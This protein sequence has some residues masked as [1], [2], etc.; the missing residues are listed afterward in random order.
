MALNGRSLGA[1]TVLRQGTGRL[2]RER[3]YVSSDSLTPLTSLGSSQ[4]KI[5]SELCT[6]QTIAWNVDV[7][8]IVIHGNP[9]DLCTNVGDLLGLKSVKFSMSSYVQVR[10]S[11]WQEITWSLSLNMTARWAMLKWWK[12]ICYSFNLPTDCE[13]VVSYEDYLFILRKLQGFVFVSETGLYNSFDT[14]PGCAIFWG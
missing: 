3:K 2:A 9:G 6:I 1:V 7:W 4:V 5:P 10:G 14:Y 11:T 13:L 8:W 12:A